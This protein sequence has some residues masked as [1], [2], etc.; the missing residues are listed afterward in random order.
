MVSTNIGIPRRCQCPEIAAEFC[1]FL[2]SPEIQTSVE[3]KKMVQ[4]VRM[5][6]YL[7]A[8]KHQCGFS[9]EESRRLLENSFFFRNMN[10]KEELAQYFMI[11]EIREELAGLFDGKLAPEQAADR[12]IAKWRE[13]SA[14]RL[15]S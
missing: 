4:P 15:W 8:M 1:R 2:L 3:T 6:A 9:A 5:E 10:H 11:F 13:F 14:G 7:E 12:I